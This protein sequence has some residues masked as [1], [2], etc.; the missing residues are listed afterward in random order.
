MVN[1]L[2]ISNVVC[3]CHFV[4]GVCCANVCTFC[5]FVWGQLY[6]CWL[7]VLVAE[8]RFVHQLYFFVCSARCYLVLLML[9]GKTTQR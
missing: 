5:I 6:L 1:C 8:T 9:A 2:I 7:N 3:Q 4:K